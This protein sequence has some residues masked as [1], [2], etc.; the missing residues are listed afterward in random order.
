MTN[1]LT[2]VI[3]AVASPAWGI[4]AVL[5]LDSVLL[6]IIYYPS[7]IHMWARH[8]VF[9]SLSEA[10]LYVQRLLIVVSLTDESKILCMYWR[11]D[12][13]WRTGTVDSFRHWIKLPINLNRLEEIFLDGR[14]WPHAHAS[15]SLVRCLRAP[16][17]PKSWRRH[18]LH[19]S[20]T[21][22]FNVLVFIEQ[23][24]LNFEITT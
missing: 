15:P 20:I 10:T 21:Y 14:T 12:N 23:Q 5:L 16:P 24:I 18:C 9:L 13:R 7:R 19:G 8:G 1:Y 22:D 2:R 3:H 6:S 17:R 11:A 4:G